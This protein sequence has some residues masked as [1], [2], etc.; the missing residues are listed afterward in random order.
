M[1]EIEKIREKAL[2]K[3]FNLPIS[4]P[5]IGLILEAGTWPANQK[6]QY[7]IIILYHNR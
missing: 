3:I 7:S 5:H 1:N 2:I 4:L 6:I